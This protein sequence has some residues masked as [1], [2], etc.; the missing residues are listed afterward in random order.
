MGIEDLPYNK[1]YYNIF[2][3]CNEFRQRLADLQRLKKTDK[4]ENESEDVS[5]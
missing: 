5:K 1:A 3:V 2:G 4:Q